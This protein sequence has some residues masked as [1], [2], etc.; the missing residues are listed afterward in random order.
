MFKENGR[1]IWCELKYP[2][3]L[4]PLSKRWKALKI[5]ILK[6]KRWRCRFLKD[7]LENIWKLLEI[8]LIFAVRFVKK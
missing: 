5:D 8:L 3:L 6:Q 7:F 4:H 2:L 1:Y